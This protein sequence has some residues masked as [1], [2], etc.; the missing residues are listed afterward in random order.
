MSKGDREVIPW[1]YRFVNKHDGISVEVIEQG[2]DSDGPSKAKNLF[3][4]SIVLVFFLTM[5]I[6][7]Y[8]F[9]MNP[10]YLNSLSFHPS[11]LSFLEFHLG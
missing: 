10:L 4:G 2:F 1:R 5:F 8:F 6:V 11:S 7:I 9:G 3:I